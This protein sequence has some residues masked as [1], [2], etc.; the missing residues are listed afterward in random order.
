LTTYNE[1]KPNGKTRLNSFSL[2]L[3]Q[4]IVSESQNS[5][6]SPTYTNDKLLQIINQKK[7]HSWIF[8]NGLNL[9]S[10]DMEIVY[11]YLLQNNTV[12]IIERF[13]LKYK[14]RSIKEN[15]K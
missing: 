7:N 14:T 3:F 10:E 1:T 12:M 15:K 4:F 13:N 8:L 5:I 9:T 11:Y 6:P 2:Y